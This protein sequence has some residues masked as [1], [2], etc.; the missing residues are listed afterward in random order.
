[1]TL[2]SFIVHF[3][4][5][6]IGACEVA[7]ILL[8]LYCLFG[9]IGQCVLESLQDL[10]D[11][12]CADPD[13]CGVC[14]SGRSSC[15]VARG[16]DAAPAPSLGVNWTEPPRHLPRFSDFRSAFDGESP[17]PWSRARRRYRPVQK[18]AHALRVDSRCAQRRDRR[19]G[20][21]ATA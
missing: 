13:T 18:N 2:Y 19:A 6:T 16:G 17:D 8:T 9:T 1:M 3:F 12:E 4:A 5:Y 11:S 7:G 10:P 21:L 20:R 15:A 14:E